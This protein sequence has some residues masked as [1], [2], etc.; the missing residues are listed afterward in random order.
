MVEK[1]MILDVGCGDRPK[2]DV[3]LDL[4]E[5]ESV[6]LQG[7]RGKI[8]PSETLNFVQGTV[9]NLPFKNNIFNKVLCHHLLEHL[10]QPKKAIKELIRV[11]NCEIEIIV[12]YKWHEIIQNWFMPQR[13]VWA[14]KHHLW[15]FTKRQLTTLFIEMNLHPSIRYQYKF[16]GALTYFKR[17]QKRDFKQFIIYGMLEA[18]LP[19]TPGELKVTII[20]AVKPITRAK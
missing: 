1:T 19:P 9:Y 2:G 12:P 13:R 3:N 17:I 20:K 18:F 11:S 8:N 16:S 4:F 10:K 15:N 7:S 5:G 6:D 14:K